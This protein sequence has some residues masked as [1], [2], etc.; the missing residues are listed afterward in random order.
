MRKDICHE[1]QLAELERGDVI[2]FWPDTVKPVPWSNLGVFYR[3]DL[4][5]KEFALPAIKGNTIYLISICASKLIPTDSGA[6]EI[7]DSSS[8]PCEEIAPEDPRYQELSE[9]VKVLDGSNPS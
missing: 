5:A 8:Y 3:N 4:H 6:I 2:N 9:L 1:Y 7:R